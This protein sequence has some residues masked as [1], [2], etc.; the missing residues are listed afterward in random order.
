[1]YYNLTNLAL[2]LSRSLA[3]RFIEGLAEAWRA[4]FRAL[5]NSWRDYQGRRDQAR[6]FDAVAHLNEHVLKDIG[7]PNSLIARAAARRQAGDLHS[8]E[9]ERSLGF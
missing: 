3:S 4:A 7:A 6:A 1:M 2:V 9:I 8:D 5:R